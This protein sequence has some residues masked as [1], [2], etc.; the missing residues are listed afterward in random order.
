MVHRAP[1]AVRLVAGRRRRRTTGSRPSAGRPGAP[2]RTGAAGTCT[3][4]T[5]SSPTSTG[6]TRTCVARDAGDVLRFWLD[7]GVDGF[8]VDAIDRLLKDAELRDDPPASGTFP[9][10]HGNPEFARARPRQLD[11]TPRHRRRDR[12]DPRRGGRRRLARRRGL[13]GRRRGAPL[14]RVVRPRVRVRAVLRRLGRR[15]PPP[16]GDRAR[17]RPG[18]R[19]GPVEPRL[20]AACRRA[21]APTTSRAA[22]LLLLT[23]PGT[24]FVYQGEEIGL[25]GRARRTTRRTTAPAATARATRCSGSARP[26]AA[27]RPARRGSRRSTR[28][29]ATWPTRSDDPDSLL[30]LYRR[31]I[32]LRR[33]FTSDGHPLP[34]LRARHARLRARR[35]ARR[36]H[37]RRRDRGA[38]HGPRRGAARGRRRL[39]RTN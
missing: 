17:R 26:T 27:S 4:S 30:N 24:A 9:L 3:R 20:P 22:A 12:R 34:R 14:P 23:L 11:R 18:R 36:R 16:R 39:R 29:A 21:S 8:R 1:G 7:R 6:A 37:R 19:L 15:E 28:D 25:A 32:E 38:G 2:T 31:L 13:P 10:P 33:S 5:P 35:R